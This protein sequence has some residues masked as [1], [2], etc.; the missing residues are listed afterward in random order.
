MKL[1][2][3][4]EKYKLGLIAILL[5]GSCLFTYYFHA[6]LGTGSVFTHFFYIPII[7]ASLWWR[8]KGLGVALF[9]AIFLVFGYHFLRDY[10]VTANDYVRALMFVVIGFVAATLSERIAKA[11]KRSAHLT[12]VLHAIQGINQLI[13]R[14]KNPGKLLKGVCNDLIETRSYRNAWIA[15]LDTSGDL[16]TTAEAGLG[17]EFLPMIDYL[18]CGQMSLCGKKALKQSEIIVTE[19]PL[20]MCADC[21]LSAMTGGR[22]AMTARLEYDGKV[23]GPLCVSASRDLTAD[24]EEQALLKVIAGDISFAFH[25]LELGEELKK[26]R[27]REHL[28]Q[29]VEERT[30]QLDNVNEQLKQHI[31]ERKHVEEALRESKNQYRILFNNTGDAIFIQEVDGGF[32]QVNQMACE[33]LGYSQEELLQ[34]KPHNITTPEH[35]KQI[36]K[37][38]NKILQ[39]SHLIFETVQVTRDGKKIPTEVSSQLIEYAGKSAILSIARDITKRKKAEAE[40]RKLVSQLQQAQRMEA[41]GTLAGGIAHDFNNILSP[42]IGYSELTLIDLPQDS[43]VRGNIHEVLNAG[44]RAKELVKQILT[45]SRQSEQERKPVQIN[46]IVKEVLTL[47]HSLLPATI[48]IRQNILATGKVLADATQIHQVMMNLCTNA[49]HAMREKGGVLEVS[50]SDVDLDS[51]STEV[52]PPE[53]APGPYVRVTVSDTGC[54]MNCA[55]MDRIFEPYYTTKEEGDGNGMGLAMV[56]GIVKSHNGA[57]TVYSEPGKS[58]T[59]HVFFPKIESTEGVAEIDSSLDEIPRGKGRILLVDDEKAL[60]DIDKNI[61]EHL[62]YEAVTRTSSIEALEAFRARPEKYDL[63]ITDMTMPNMTGTELAKELM[64]IRSD[65]P[66]ILCTGFSDR[67]N[68]DR[69]TAMGI[70]KLLMKPVAIREMAEGIRHVLDRSYE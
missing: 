64:S 40:K 27:E 32:L 28:E 4:K 22:G 36:P 33:R 24:E 19:D 1:E 8:R 63:V 20:S 12:A 2:R 55:V 62:G 3:Q 38:I 29:L 35:S 57:I 17:K 11:Q 45:F 15:L 21:P 50:M 6:V 70:R 56:H 31:S 53:L 44:R 7:L 13:I 59:F 39:K 42:I 26:H 30:A 9:L 52:R 34:I 46:L 48:E 66:V 37:R 61:L 58:S 18:K 69:A 43:R 25:S 47:M 10:V 23:Y 14:E 16:V 60:V 5:A 65:I 67:I 68:K 54:G 49:Y 51:G 41:I